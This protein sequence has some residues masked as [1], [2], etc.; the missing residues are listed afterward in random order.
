MYVKVVINMW[1]LRSIESLIWMQLDWLWTKHINGS[2]NFP[3]LKSAPGL[4][5]AE[6]TPGQ[7]ETANRAVVCLSQRI[8][9]GNL[10]TLV[11]YT[12][13]QCTPTS[14]FARP[15]CKGQWYYLRSI[16]IVAILSLEEFILGHEGR[17]SNEALK[18]LEPNSQQRGVHLC[19]LSC[20]DHLPVLGPKNEARGG[21]QPRFNMYFKN[22]CFSF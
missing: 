19:Q 7:R 17:C 3:E 11:R 15:S 8:S 18:Q 21:G 1:R 4:K 5:A 9:M 20:E 12:Y 16:C 6:D 2:R 14:C 22:Y 13:F 10:K